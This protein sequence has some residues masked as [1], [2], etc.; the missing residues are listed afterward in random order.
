MPIARPLVAGELPVPERRCT[1]S[2]RSRC[3]CAEAVEA[4]RRIIRGV[5]SVDARKAEPRGVLS[6]A[7]D[8]DPARRCLTDVMVAA[9]VPPLRG[10]VGR[11]DLET[12]GLILV[13]A[14]ALL[15]EAALN[16]SRS[17]GEQPAAQ[18][19]TKTYE[20][21][22]RGRH[23]ADALR[24]LGEP[25]VHRRGGR[26]RRLMRARFPLSSPSLARYPRAARAR[27][28]R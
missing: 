9:G 20:L 26:V 6:A 25:L 24:S 28:I 17:S 2:W 21:L 22:L 18:P 8:A 10:H 14:D 12:S 27:V 23:E 4:W 13:T 11:L 15:L 7:S 19:L 5:R 3:G 1:V 16:I